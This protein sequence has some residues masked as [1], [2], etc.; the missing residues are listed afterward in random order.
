MAL[1]GAINVLM[2]V[3]LYGA[4]GVLSGFFHARLNGSTKT[5]AVLN[6]VACAV[7]VVL[8]VAITVEIL[9]G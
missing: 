2:E 9:L 6:Y 3:L 1:L 7:Y 8:A 4:I 5:T